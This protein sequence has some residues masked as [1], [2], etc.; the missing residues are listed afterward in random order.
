MTWRV[1]FDAGPA[2][3]LRKAD[4]GFVRP[5]R[6]ARTGLALQGLSRALAGLWVFDAGDRCLLLDIRRRNRVVIALTPEEHRGC[7]GHQ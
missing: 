2:Q 6:A 1:L 3:S 5:I 4:P 7:P